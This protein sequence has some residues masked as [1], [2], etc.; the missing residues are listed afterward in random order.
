MPRRIPTHQASKPNRKLTYAMFNRFRA[1]KEDAKFYSC[2]R[3]KKKRLVVL[4][5]D[6]LCVVCK[7]AGRL[8]PSTIADHILERKEHPHLAWDLKNLRGVCESCH[9]SKTRTHLHQKAK[10]EQERSAGETG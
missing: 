2:A 4:K 8:V 10:D 6:P 7:A 5:R 3:W 1:D 9:N